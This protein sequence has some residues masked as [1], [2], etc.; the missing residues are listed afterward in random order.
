MGSGMLL[1]SK[2]LTSASAICFAG[3]GFFAASAQD[4]GSAPSNEDLYKMIRADHEVL[5][6]VKA[7]QERLKKE[8]ARLKSEAARAAAELAA[9]RK[10]LV[11][12]TKQPKPRF[13]AVA[14]PV[15]AAY[16]G[17]VAPG[18]QPPYGTSGGVHAAPAPP[19]PLFAA[20]AYPGQLPAVSS[21][22]GK[23]EAAGGALNDRAAGFAAAALS[24]PVGESLGFQA[25]SLVGGKEG[26][27]AIG[28]AAHLFWRDPNI[29]LL[30][31]YGSV[32]HFDGA[33]RNGDYVEK[34][35][36]TAE[37][38]LGRFSIESLAGWERDDRRTQSIFASGGGCELDG[39]TNR[40][41]DKVDLAYYA[42]D[43]W[44]VS[45]GH[46]FDNGRNALAL[47]TEYLLSTPPGVNV[48]LFANAR[49]GDRDN[50]AFVAG[51][52]FYFGD[53]GKTLIQRHRED[54]PSIDLVDDY[55]S[56]G[57][58]LPSVASRQG[59][60]TLNAISAG[61]VGIAVPGTV[62]IDGPTGLRVTS[63]TLAFGASGVFLAP[64]APGQTPSI[65][66]TP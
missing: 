6:G 30:G 8:N 45:A 4:V 3:L 31:A 24:V 58:G 54:D 62:Q 11:L 59:T 10:A 61:L 42:S 29:A 63:P 5:V 51:A 16:S 19:A 36:L 27:A 12:A 50:R 47:G 39:H 55:F 32:S 37:L 57:A 41:F 38:Y 7:E 9:T 25:D 60:V 2:L 66:I 22:N 44:R 56:Q 49:I 20:T 48:S 26:G 1:R 13:A 34:A 14:P 23:I 46:R 64:C 18:S 43:N 65:S 33:S 28:T 40:F 35:G 21:V 52:K 15:N 17:T 53:A